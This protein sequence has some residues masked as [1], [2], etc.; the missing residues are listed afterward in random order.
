MKL[1][2]RSKL[3]SYLAI[4]A[5][6]GVALVAVPT[7][8]SPVA[9]KA[10]IQSP[11]TE[12]S[13]ATTGTNPTTNSPPTVHSFTL[14]S[15]NPSVGLYFPSNATVSVQSSSPANITI[16]T[17]KGGV[18]AVTITSSA[19]ANVTVTTTPKIASAAP[20]SSNIPDFALRLALVLVPALFLSSLGLV[21]VRRQVKREL[22]S[23]SN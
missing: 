15:T 10:F 1:G 22:E 21:R 17:Y 16:A 3:G 19:P 4:W 7:L 13:I 18:D 23:D 12:T 9:Q 14:N 2:K 11:N 5:L 20:I 6:L 8:I